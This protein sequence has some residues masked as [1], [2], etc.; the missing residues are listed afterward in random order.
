MDEAAEQGQAQQVGGEDFPHRGPGRRFRAGRGGILRRL[1]FRR[2]G[3]EQPEVENRNQGG[4][5]GGEEQHLP[6]RQERLAGHGGD[7]GA[8]ADHPQR[9]PLQRAHQQLR[10]DQCH[11]DH[12]QG[13]ARGLRRVRRVHA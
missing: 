12:G 9:R 11:A 5:P 8:D 3:N 10:E 13:D 4:N 7:A 1:P 6:G 2:L